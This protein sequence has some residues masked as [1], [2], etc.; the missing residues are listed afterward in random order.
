MKS[1]ADGDASRL[2]RRGC[3]T[4]GEAIEFIPPALSSR[5]RARDKAAAR[6]LGYG[7]PYLSAWINL[8]RAQK[9][10]N[11]PTFRS[12]GFDAATLSRLPVAC[13]ALVA[14]LVSWLWRDGCG[15]RWW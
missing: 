7:M 15:C 10:R 2:R 6:P 13:Q 11:P 12:P 9:R 3:G 4:E 5:R 8:E 14:P 1:A